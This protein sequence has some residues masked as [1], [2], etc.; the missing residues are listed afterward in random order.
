MQITF[1][2]N[3]DRYKKN[4]WP[5]NFIRHPQKG[6]FVNVSKGFQQYYL[7]QGLPTALEVKSVNHFEQNGEQI[8]ICELWFSDLQ[9]QLIQQN[10]ID[11]T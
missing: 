3:I 6:E 9:Y 5:T 7:D 1:H 2:T 11:W 10:N 8:I 4:C